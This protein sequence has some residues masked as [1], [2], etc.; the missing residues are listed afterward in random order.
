MTGPAGLVP[1][2]PALARCLVVAGGAVISAA[3]A[4]LAGGLP[5]ASGGWLARA[6]WLGAW[7][8]CDGG[9][10]FGRTSDETTPGSR[11][12]GGCGGG[13]GCRSAGGHGRGGRRGWLGRLAGFRCQPAGPGDRGARPGALSAGGDARSA[14]CRAARRATA[15]PAGLHGPLRSHPGVRGQRAERGV[16]PGG[17]GAWPGRPGRRP[18]RLG[19]VGVVRLGGQLRGN[20]VLH[21]PAPVTCGVRG[22][23]AERGWGGRSR[24]P[25]WP[26]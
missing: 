14:R 18:G 9:P 26:P 25:A 8:G 12:A 17:R 16:G 15:R 11:G 20:R 1:W 2:R 5:V 7:P 22:Q 4:V 23:R 21:R 24:C 3:V 19:L 6:W 10:G 13:V